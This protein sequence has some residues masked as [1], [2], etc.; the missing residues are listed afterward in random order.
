MIG[1]E[2]GRDAGAAGSADYDLT[3][4]DRTGV[5]IDPDAWGWGHNTESLS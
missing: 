2:D 1:H 3:H 5:G 4:G